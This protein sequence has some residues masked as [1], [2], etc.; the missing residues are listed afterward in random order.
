MFIATSAWNGVDNH[1]KTSDNPKLRD[2]P[3]N[4]FSEVSKS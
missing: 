3:Q 4:N 1:E 2:I